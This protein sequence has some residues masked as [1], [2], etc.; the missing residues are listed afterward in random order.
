MAHH[1]EIVAQL[2]IQHHGIKD[3]D[4]FH[5]VKLGDV[6]ILVLPD[7]KDDKEYGL[8]LSHLEEMVDSVVQRLRENATLVTVGTQVDLVHVHNYIGAALEFQHWIA[9]KSTKQNCSDNQTFLPHMHFGATIHTKYKGT[10]QHTL[11]RIAYTYCPVCDKSTKDYGGKKNSYH[12]YG[13][14]ISD[15][16]RDLQA[17]L[18]GD[19]SQVV[20]RFADLFGIE[21][22]SRL[23]VL[24]CRTMELKRHKLSSEHPMRRRDLKT[25][26][27]TKPLLL[28][29]CLN[30]LRTL[31][32]NSVDFVFADPPYNLRK[33]YNNYADDM[34]ITTYF[35]WCDQWVSE[36]VR[37]L[38]P[39]GTCAILNIPLW[40]IRHFLHL[41]KELEFQNWIV[42]DALSF[43]VRRIM[44]AHYAILCFTKG[45]ARPLPGLLPASQKPIEFNS[46]FENFVPL[47]PLGEEYCR[48]AGCVNHRAEIGHNDRGELG[49]LWWDIHRLRHNSRRVDH[50]CQLPPQLMYRLISIFTSPGEVVLDCFNGAGTTTL[51]AHQ[52]GRKYIG[53][54]LS[55][56]YHEMA[57]ERHA[58]IESGL[59]PFRKEKRQLGEKNSA[60]KRLGTTKYAVPK[61]ALQLDVKRVAELLGHIPSREEMKEYGEHPIHYYDEY[62]LS[63]GE[64]SAAA[65]TTG[66]SERRN[67]RPKA[68]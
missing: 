4:T 19:I 68:V 34:E 13:T 12:Y 26:A 5:S 31:P 9:I 40:A 20:E 23:T 1:S 22:Y 21:E 11:T 28:G 38:K 56:K 42:W 37:V 33:Q 18:S 41:E 39:G 51:A 52:L 30:V 14:L 25:S 66:M 7:C 27:P 58:E 43:P 48:R 8:H 16:W 67:F 54:E 29:D 15:V 50:P 24:D 3:L 47:E 32:S 60:D 17:D 62:F 55:P 6:C 57:R 46:S 63:W 49:D 35:E 45:P 64:V 65:R 44:P 2:L 53:I 61:N 59:D 10:L 36:L